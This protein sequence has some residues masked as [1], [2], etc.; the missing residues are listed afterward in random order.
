MG[1]LTFILI[2]FVVWAAVVGV[3]VA[4]CRAAAQADANVEHPHS[5]PIAPSP[6]HPVRILITPH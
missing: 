6:R 4:M 1:F 3:A 2:G 5:H